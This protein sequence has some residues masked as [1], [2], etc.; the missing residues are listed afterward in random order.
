[1]KRNKQYT[2]LETVVIPYHSVYSTN[3]ELAAYAL[4]N[5][6]DFDVERMVEKLLADVSGW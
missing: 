2:M 4:A 1:M 6:D 3:P 5:C